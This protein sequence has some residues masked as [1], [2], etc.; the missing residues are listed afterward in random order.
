[1]ELG[2]HQRPVGIPELTGLGGATV[3]FG[4]PRNNLLALECTVRESW[5]LLYVWDPSP[6]LCVAE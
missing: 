4:P 3:L 6:D 5:S 1:M 2:A